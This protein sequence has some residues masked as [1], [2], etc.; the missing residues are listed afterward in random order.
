MST[1]FK[2]IQAYNAYKTS[3][4]AGLVF[5]KTLD[6]KDKEEFTPSQIELLLFNALVSKVD[7]IDNVFI[8]HPEFGNCTTKAGKEARELWRS[9][10]PDYLTKIN[11]AETQYNRL[12]AVADKFR[13]YFSDEANTS[14][15]SRSSSIRI[16]MFDVSSEVPVIYN[17][18]KT[19]VSFVIPTSSSDIKYVMQKI[20]AYDLTS[21]TQLVMLN[22]R[23]T[24]TQFN[25][26][27]VNTDTLDYSV[28]ATILDENTLKAAA[29]NI[30]QAGNNYDIVGDITTD[31]TPNLIGVYNSSGELWIV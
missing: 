21:L 28:I 15:D 27:A 30:L 4:N 23:E 24:V 2:L 17:N 31:I 9:N 22:I 10:N 1:Y 14:C 7:F 26:I 29:D 19:V 20:N 3:P 16:S 8:I 13:E 11:V 5:S 18:D 25:I 12:R 6:N